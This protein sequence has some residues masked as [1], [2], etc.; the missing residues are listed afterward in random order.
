MDQ[1]VGELGYTYTAL[2]LPYQDTSYTN[3]YSSGYVYNQEQ[4]AYNG[5]GQVTDFYQADSGAV[6]TLYTA[7]VQYA[8]EGKKRVETYPPS[9]AD[10]R[11]REGGA[12][13]A[14]GPVRFV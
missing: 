12:A 5:F 11:P 10:H 13:A 3:S 8:Y 7:D 4:F 14:S 1:G 9:E 2:G 6:N